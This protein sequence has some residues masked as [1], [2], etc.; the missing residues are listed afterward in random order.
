MAY[1]ERAYPQ[2]GEIHVTHASIP[3]LPSHIGSDG[4]ERPQ[5]V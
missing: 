5:G 4:V 1:N 3:G 2:C